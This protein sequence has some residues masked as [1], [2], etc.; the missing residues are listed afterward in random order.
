[1]LKG[2]LSRRI[3]RGLSNVAVIVIALLL[4]VLFWG[5]VRFVIG[6]VT[7]LLALAIQIGVLILIFMGI[8]YAIKK[9]SN[10]TS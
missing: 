1:M 7:G 6:A 4:I 9:L 5:V 3:P 8:V 2:I 10:K